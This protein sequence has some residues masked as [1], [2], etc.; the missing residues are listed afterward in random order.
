MESLTDVTAEY[1]LKYCSTRWLYIGKVIV[2]LLE[3]IENLKQYFLTFLPGQKNFKG[4]KGVDS[5]ERYQRIKVFEQ[6][7]AAPYFLNHL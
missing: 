1:L 6:Q 5:T 2:R 3:Q 7:N 4:K